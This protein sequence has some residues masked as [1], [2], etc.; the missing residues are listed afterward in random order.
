MEGGACPFV[1]EAAGSSVFD[2]SL[3][4]SHFW[5]GWLLSG[6]MDGW[7]IHKLTFID[8]VPSKTILCVRWCADVC[9]K[10]NRSAAA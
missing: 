2:H 10:Y 9:H 6:S 7:C 4:V 1:C 5:P 8:R 3:S